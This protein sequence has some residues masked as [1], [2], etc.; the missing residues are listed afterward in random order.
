MKRIID[1]ATLVAITASIAV[2]AWIFWLSAKKPVLATQFAVNHSE[3]IRFHDS[4]ILEHYNDLDREDQL[5]DWLLYT[6]VSASNLDAE[7]MRNALYDVPP[8]RAGYIRPIAA[9]DFG[10]TRYRVIDKDG[11][12]VALIPAGHPRRSEL[13][14]QIADAAR[15]S[16]G[17]KPSSVRVFEYTL[18][19]VELTAQLTRTAD[20]RGD[21][22]FTSAY[23][24]HE[25]VVGDPKQLADFL[26]QNGD[27]VL[28]ST[29]DGDLK[30]GGREIAGS[31]PKLR[32][33]DVAALWQ[34]EK[35]L[36]R[37]REL[38]DKFKERWSSEEQIRSILEPIYE[39]ELNEILA[40]YPDTPSLIPP[41]REGLDLF[42]EP[43]TSTGDALQ[44]AYR[45][46]LGLRAVP[47]TDSQSG[48]LQPP[49]SLKD[50]IREQIEN[51]EPKTA[52][53]EALARLKARWSDQQV[54]KG[55][56]EPIR[57]GEESELKKKLSSRGS[58]GI[59]DGSG[60]SLDPSFRY[61]QL[62]EVF[63]KLQPLLSAVATPSRMAAIR[64][65]IDHHKE[66]SFLDLLYEVQK[67]QYGVFG[68]IGGE[69]IDH[70][71]FQ[72]ARYDG[73]LAGTEVGM[74]LFYTDLLAK[75]WALDYL[76]TAPEHQI[77]G[78]VPM[79]KVSVSPIYDRETRELSNTRLWFGPR[80]SGFAKAERKITFARVATRV[81][82]ASSNTLQPGKEA[83]PNAE[84]AEFLGW[85]NDHYAQ[86]AGF[87]PQYQRLNEIM[88][89]SVVLG[90]LASTDDLD[91]LNFLAGVPVKRDNWF[92]DWAAANRQLRFQDWNR[93]P[94]Y[95]R[96]YEGVDTESMPLLSSREYPGRGGY[97]VLI[98]GISLGSRAELGERAELP[99][100]IDPLARRAN[101]LHAD[102]APGS[103]AF[104]SLDN[105]IYEFRP[106]EAWNASAL[107]MKPSTKLRGEELEL[108]RNEFQMSFDR[109]GSGL[110]AT[111]A[112][113]Y[114]SIGALD[115]ET[116]GSL[117]EVLFESG[118][119]AYS[120]A[121]S[122]TLSEATVAGDRPLLALAGRPDV[123]RVIERSGTFYVEPRDGGA[124]WI[125]IT[126]ETQ[127][128]VNI[129]D[130]A[131]LRFG[132][133]GST[134]DQASPLWNV[135]FVN[136]QRVDS[137]LSDAGY[138]VTEAPPTP[139]TGAA[140]SVK[141]RGPPPPPGSNFKDLTSEPVDERSVLASIGDGNSGG[142]RP[143]GANGS[144]GN[145]GSGGVGGSGGGNGG[146]GGGG[147]GSGNE[148]KGAPGFWGDDDRPES[149]ARKAAH[150]PDGILLLLGERRRAGVERADGM[151]RTGKL[152][153]ARDELDELSNV[154]PDDPNIVMRRVLVHA[155]NRSST[156]AAQAAVLDVP[157]SRLPEFLDI[158]D[159]VASHLQE[160]SPEFRQLSAVV[161]GTSAKAHGK[162]VRYVGT[163][164]EFGMEIRLFDFKPKPVSSEEARQVEAATRYSLENVDFNPGVDSPPT[165]PA[166]E[167]ITSKIV[168]AT[169]ALTEPD[170]I[171]DLRTGRRY[172]RVDPSSATRA[173]QGRMSFRARYSSSSG[174][175]SAMSEDERRQHEDCRDSVYLVDDKASRSQLVAA[176]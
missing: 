102:G 154:Y 6:V 49:K 92:P 162:Q 53:Q 28:A 12:V 112:S 174:N 128:R 114:D 148:S 62:R 132:G 84:S 20:I 147:G 44:D 16:L 91:K 166:S 119:L 141:N 101:V 136:R 126:P 143:G 18:D 131:D 60:F 72:H 137:E 152:E 74:V 140:F 7:A 113:G 158:A 120:A 2:I 58:E 33:E 77:R 144:D 107:S 4:Q 95:Q 104:K 52:R 133:L 145:G 63:D 98:G 124:I 65:D 21:D 8:L 36:G 78:F 173:S 68:E 14:A 61:T 106:I 151:I 138:V 105:T 94:F 71:K 121:F 86:V 85:W 13:L 171:V 22:L 41:P 160:G 83:E 110:R 59:A 156:T 79:L 19:P 118:R 26:N 10:E 48:G 149:V 146:S 123:S 75:L 11:T 100:D 135:T 67:G 142:K 69:A 170:A 150:D 1:A 81:Y 130:D 51:G 168:D 89:W 167:P 153:Q 111:L 56:L 66:E 88:K 122:R 176:K 42:D 73:S 32:V 27:I 55:I 116:R 25:Q 103:T 108:K 40:K 163:P 37:D 96:G 9:F 87:E 125:K 3:R 82:A 50:R 39:K 97:H 57:D 54:L 155:A 172:S 23:G 165:P 129:A 175:C 159:Q 24:Y 134:S 93:V 34:S 80:D 35:Q 46:S 64:S 117:T 43:S 115:I 5:R 161:R 90:W 169:L 29:A 139:Q 38:V 17:S 31:A 164:R 157:S 70:A 127:P 76:E 109:R 99:A 30:L 47:F 45:K 15:N